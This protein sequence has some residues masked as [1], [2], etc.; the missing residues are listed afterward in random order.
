MNERRIRPL[1]IIMSCQEVV[2]EKFYVRVCEALENKEL[3]ILTW[4]V[5]KDDSCYNLILHDSI[6][7]HRTDILRWLPR[8]QLRK[9]DR[10]TFFASA[11][12]APNMDMFNFLL[13][14]DYVAGQ[15]STT[16]LRLAE[17][18]HVEMLRILVK[19]RGW[20]L[21]EEMFDAALSLGCSQMLSCL[22]ELDCPHAD[23]QELY[24][25]TRE[26][27]L[28]WLL[29]NLPLTEEEMLEVCT[30]G[31]DDVLFHLIRQGHLP[32]EFIDDANITLSALQQGF[33]RAIEEYLAQ[34]YTFYD[35]IC[36]WIENETSLGWLIDHQINLSSDLYYRLVRE[37]NLPLLE[38]LSRLMV[39]PQDLLD[40]TFTLAQEHAGT[41]RYKQLNEV[42]EWIQQE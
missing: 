11:C 23:V 37:T 17:S 4:A 36:M 12:S 9:V 10:R 18:P 7:Y 42:A 22:L 24:L 6:H 14:V 13:D 31:P 34:G 40:Y 16:S 8:K 26:E 32:E 39:I 29:N 19:E 30:N 15:T 5:E 1:V 41:E 25:T 2:D 38:K 3:D 21:S 35:D 28:P 33:T 20:V 27:N